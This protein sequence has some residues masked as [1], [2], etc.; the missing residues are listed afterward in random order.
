VDRADEETSRQGEEGYA[1]LEHTADVGIR[2]WGETIERAFEQAA[3]GLAD[4]L[5]ARGSGGGPVQALAL[6]GPDS[7]SVLVD[8]LNELIAILETQD[9]SIAEV[10]VRSVSEGTLRGDVM[11]VPRDHRPEGVVVKAATYHRLSLKRRP[12]GVE[13]RVYLDV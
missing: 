11:L 6:S 10:H 1:F 9:G 13:A 3:L 8:F 7:E 12:S 5:D 2:A 4:L